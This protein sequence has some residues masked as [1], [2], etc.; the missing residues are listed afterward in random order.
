MIRRS[1]T[2][3]GITVKTVISFDEEADQTNPEVAQ[4]IGEATL[5]GSLASVERE[6]FAIMKAEGLPTYHGCYLHDAEGAWRV[7]S[8]P[9]GGARIVN[10]IW[11]IARARGHAP[12]SRVG[13]A[14]RMLGDVVW[15]R[16]AR[17]AGD[18]DRAALFHGYLMAKRA[19][20]RIKVHH[21]PTWETGRDVR[22]ILDDQR[23]RAI[24]AKQGEAE[25]NRALWQAEA[26]LIWEI[27]PNL[28]RRAVGKLIEIKLS[29]VGVEANADTI[30]RV[31]KKVGITG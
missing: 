13:F 2:G 5:D 8:P 29:K 18:H 19:E 21:E 4:L 24:A 26:D 27:R 25:E 10:E 14:S 17:E 20:Q 12:D 1:T 3:T 7:P 23:E 9:F 15:L 31:I 28:S 22:K 30:R 6:C 11:P 16:R